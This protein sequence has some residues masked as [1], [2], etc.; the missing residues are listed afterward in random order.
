MAATVFLPKLAA[1]LR[2]GMERKEFGRPSRLNLT[3]M[4]LPDAPEIRNMMAR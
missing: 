3:A 1:Q 4:G 2:K